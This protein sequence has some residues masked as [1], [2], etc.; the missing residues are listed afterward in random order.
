MI[1]IPW[2]CWL[3]LCYTDQISFNVTYLNNFIDI[4]MGQTDNYGGKEAN[5]HEFYV[6]AP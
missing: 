4:I 6:A 3:Q 1:K 5:R 2:I